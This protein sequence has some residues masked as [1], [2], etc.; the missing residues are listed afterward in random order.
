MT[1][2][3]KGPV[4]EFNIPRTG[5]RMT[6][7]AT[8]KAS[9]N[10]RDPAIQPSQIWPQGE[11]SATAAGNRRTAS[12]TVN[13]SRTT[14]AAISRTESPLPFARVSGP[15]MTASGLEAK[16]STG[17]LKLITMIHKSGNEASR[18]QKTRNP[19]EVRRSG[20]DWRRAVGVLTYGSL[21]G[22]RARCG[23]AGGSG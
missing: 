5:G 18:H 17:S 15:R 20:K 22:G 12:R 13:H 3:P 14:P 23:G 10:R 1:G 21:P 7:K 16:A 2:T 19:A 4:T 8:M 11:W 6:K 9:P